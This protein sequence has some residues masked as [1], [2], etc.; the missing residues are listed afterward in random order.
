V[1][2]FSQY[3]GSVACQ[4]CH[5]AQYKQQTATAHARALSRTK[6]H[7]LSSAFPAGAGEWAFGAGQQAVTFVSRV[8]DE[9]YVE[10]GE[11]YYA[12]SKSMALTP[13]HTER[14]GAQY[15]T[16]APD[17]A[18]LRCFSCHSTGPLRLASAGTIEP[19]EPGV[20]CE[21]CHGPGEA[22]VG[23]GG[24]RKLI[25]NPK[26]LSAAE[27]NQFCGSCHRK[28][29]AEEDT[30]WSQPWN[31]RH[32]PLYLVKSRCFT[33]SAGRL[34]CFTC[35]PAHA[36]VKSVDAQCRSC[37]QAVQHKTLISRRACTACHMPAVEVSENLRFANHWIGIYRPDSA[38]TPVSRP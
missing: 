12:A 17:A 37:H 1:L 19:F 36:P 7:A 30:N 4:A 10:H 23:S 16:F 13:G 2:A 20:R 22:H 21:S 3:A 5:P 26:L 6:Q 38:L 31:V 9:F 27:L 35:H 14:G 34:S 24:D 25:R 32:Q 8:N 18:I 33:A 15:R 11:S 28:H 29:S